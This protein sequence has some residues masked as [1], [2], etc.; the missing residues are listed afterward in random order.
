[1]VGSALQPGAAMVL[2]NSSNRQRGNPAMEDAMNELE[3]GSHPPGE[4]SWQ[5]GNEHVL[6]D[7][8]YYLDDLLRNLQGNVAEGEAAAGIGQGASAAHLHVGSFTWELVFAYASTAWCGSLVDYACLFARTVPLLT[9]KAWQGCE[10]TGYI[11]AGSCF[12][13]S[14][15]WLDKLNMW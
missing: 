13:Y 10:Q 6:L 1:M 15:C 5:G 14:C 12:H 11:G 9:L 2:H 7:A 8:S 3:M 4:V